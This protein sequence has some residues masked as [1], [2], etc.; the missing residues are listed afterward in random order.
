[1]DKKKKILLEA[2]FV[3]EFFEELQSRHRLVIVNTTHVKPQ[4][5]LI[6]LVSA[7]NF[8]ITIVN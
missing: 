7:P 3:Q 6:Q 4:L 1:M 2:Y 5:P 8:T